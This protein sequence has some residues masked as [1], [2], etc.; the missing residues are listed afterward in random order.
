MN[1]NHCLEQHWDI[2]EIIHVISVEDYVFHHFLALHL[3][4]TIIFINA[5]LLPFSCSTSLLP[6]AIIF[7]K[8]LHNFKKLFRISRCST[9]CKISII[10]AY[11]NRASC[12][13]W[14]ALEVILEKTSLDCTQHSR[15]SMPRFA[16]I[17]ATFV[18]ALYHVAHGYCPNGC[19]GHGSCSA[20][21]KC[22][23]YHRPNGEPAWTE[24]DCSS[25]T[26]PK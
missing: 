9:T 2:M 21:D 1:V 8:H 3:Y 6:Y 16:S 19:S 24:N 11:L 10:N 13:H 26:C 12:I 14:S 7:I 25:R 4:F 5:C 22:A 18:C 15:C 17:L 20:N 23:C